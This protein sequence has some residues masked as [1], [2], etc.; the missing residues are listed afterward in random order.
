MKICF[1]APVEVLQRPFGSG[2]YVRELLKALLSIDKSNC[3]IIW[4]GCMLKP[5]PCIASLNI[6]SGNAERVSVKVT[7]FPTRLFHHPKFRLL[8]VQF[9][10]LPIADIMFGRPTVY[11]S[12]FYPFLPFMSGELV[13]TIYDLTPLTHP[14]CHLPNTINVTRITMRWA[15]RAKRLLTFSQAVK[16]QLV[17]LFRFP[18]ERIIV[19]PLAPAKHFKPQ[20]KGF[21]ESVMRKYGLTEKF[22][23]YVGV[24][25][26]RKNLNVFLRA[27]ARLRG[28][29]PHRFVIAGSLGWYSDSVLTEIEK[30]GLQS[31]VTMVGY[32]PDD[33]LP[34]LYCGADAFV[35]P[36]LAEGFGLPVIEAMACGTPVLCSNAPA[37]QEVAG[38]AALTIDPHDEDAWT[39]ALKELLTNE[40]LRSELSGKGIERAKRFSWEQT[41]L[42]TLRAFEDAALNASH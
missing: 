5:P 28:E 29:L 26:P 21:V 25:E 17:E 1:Y 34:A 39:Y 19:T 40:E 4:Y 10:R 6:H 13:L 36:S 2:V 38:D 7:R 42:K 8:L 9:N 35:Y 23:L 3:Y 22:V 30:L 14:H 33:D 27:F 12:P 16:D 41:A 15:R 24:V 20:P 32:V 37:L 11:F 31:R 18:S